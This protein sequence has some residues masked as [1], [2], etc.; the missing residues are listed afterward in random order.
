MPPVDLY[1]AAPYIYKRTADGYLLYTAGNNGSDDGGGNEIMPDIQRTRQTISISTMSTLH[2]K[3]P[4]WRRRLVD[5][6][7][8]AATHYQESRQ[9]LANNNS[10]DISRRGLG[11]NN[12]G[13]GLVIPPLGV[14]FVR[15]G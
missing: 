7:A 4:A 9:Q 2:P 8:A 12:V 14:K 13:C 6:H 10:V 1:N 3:N 11:G 5:P 15:C